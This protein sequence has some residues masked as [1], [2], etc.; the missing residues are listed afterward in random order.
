MQK[1]ADRGVLTVQAFSYGAAQAHGDPLLATQHELVIEE[2]LEIRVAGEA[3]TLTMRTPGDDRHLALG[4]LFS[5]GVIAGLQDVGSVYHCG[6]TDDPAYGN[7]IEV[8]P[9]PGARLELERLS[10]TRRVGLTTSACGVCGRDGIDDLLA[11]LPR[12]APARA[13]VSAELLCRVPALL[14][15]GQPLFARTGGLHAACALSPTGELLAQAEDVGRHNAVDKVI[16]RLL[17]AGALSDGE[18]GLGCRAASRTCARPHLLAVSG[19]AS[20]ELVQKAAMAGFRCVASVSAPSSLA[21]ATAEAAGLTLASFVR[22]GR[23][24]LYAHPEQVF[25]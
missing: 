10:R 19:R 14:L 9:G 6:R 2:P 20:F 24:T 5:E 1:S 25:E 3:L 17:Y 13:R 15:Q 12:R 11:R 8:T 16:G 7:A 21:V 4:F 23:F 22:E 18:S